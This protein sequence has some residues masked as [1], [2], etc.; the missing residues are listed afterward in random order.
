M[1]PTLDEIIAA[2]LVFTEDNTRPCLSL[3]HVAIEGA[4]AVCGARCI[5]P[6]ME[7]DG[8]C[9]GVIVAKDVGNDQF[10]H[11]CDVHGVS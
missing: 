3:P 7:L 11:H 10:F 2:E 4:C 9:S 5:G 1:M 6:E 8:E